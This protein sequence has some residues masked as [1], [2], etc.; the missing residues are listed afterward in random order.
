MMKRILTLMLLL[1]A[2]SHVSVAQPFTYTT[3]SPIIL[4]NVN[5]LTI[6]AKQITGGSGSCITL[7]NCTNIVIT[8]CTLINAVGS[9]AY[10]ISITN[11]RNVTIEYTKIMNVSTGVFASAS[12]AVVVNQS[13]FLNMTGPYPQGS[14]VYFVNVTGGG[15]RITNNSCENVAGSSNGEVGIDIVSSSGTPTNYIYV[16]GNRMRGGGT[17]LTG[18]GII[19]GQNGG[20]YQIAQK[21]ILVS[22]GQFG[23]GVL[24]G[25]FINVSSNTIFGRLFLTNN[26]GLFYWNTSGSSSSNVTITTNKVKY[27]NQ[28][29]NNVITN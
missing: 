21:N 29:F 17:S 12:M 15:N 6:S 22:P 11:C 19:L 9:G 24:G 16:T 8:K 14:F 20:S 7:N 10:G 25:N 28:T 2:L 26:V 23:I 27:I 1:I 18:G 4:T 13:H 3:S 5:N